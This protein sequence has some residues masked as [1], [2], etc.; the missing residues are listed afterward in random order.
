MIGVVAAA[1]FFACV[2]YI[3]SQ[4]SR[5]ACAR[6]TPPHDG[7]ATG[8]PPV[9]E[10][11]VAAAL[12]GGLLMWRGALPLQMAAAVIVVF[13]LVACWCSDMTCGILPDAFTLAPLAALVLF[14]FVQRDWGI[15]LSALIP[16]VP[17]AVAA[18]F[19]RGYGMGWGD[20]KLVALTGA[21][22]G[23]PLALL[24]LAVACIAAVVG[25]R[26]TGAGRIPIAFAPY[27]AACTGLALPL[28]IVH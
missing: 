9:A 19:S 24:T 14:S 6:V 1:A 3:G 26:I 4:L 15:V 23:A 21:A 22:L 27:I 7:P 17:F 18:L 11:V 12:L 16:F 8:T 20:A 28:G 25:N 13:A 10:L 5:A 2:A